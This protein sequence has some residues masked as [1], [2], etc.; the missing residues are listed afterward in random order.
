METC[1]GV[2]FFQNS[3]IRF[4]VI[5]LFFSV[6]PFYKF[7]QPFL[8]YW[9]AK[10]NEN[11]EVKKIHEISLPF[12]YSDQITKFNVFE[13]NLDEIHFTNELI[14]I[15]I[16]FRLNYERKYI[17]YILVKNQLEKIKINE[18]KIIDDNNLK[19]LQFDKP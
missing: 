10:Q 5:M 13:L 9:Y 3:F 17:E 4:L 19:N 8:E 2:S 6:I 12:D 1:K 14:K 7:D 11:I 16:D 18:K 15:L